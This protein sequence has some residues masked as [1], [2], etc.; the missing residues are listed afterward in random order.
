MQLVAR[1]VVPA[2]LLCG[3]GAQRNIACVCRGDVVQVISDVLVKGK[4]V[5]GFVGDVVEDLEEQDAE[6]WG[7][8]CELAFGQESLTVHLRPT[9]KGYFDYGEVTKLAGAKGYDIVEGD[10]VRVTSDVVVR[11]RSALG[12]EGTVSDVWEICETDPAC[13]CAELAG[14][15]PLTVRLEAPPAEGDGTQPLVGYFSPEEV[16]VLRSGGAAGNG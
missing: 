7:A 6:E 10:R 12:W 16:Q 5:N 13:C 14:A 3:R 9:V 1:A 15:E 11:G 8:C 2:L 4:N